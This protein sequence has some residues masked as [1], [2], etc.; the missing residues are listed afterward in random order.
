MTILCFLDADQSAYSERMNAAK[1]ILVTGTS[2]V[3]GAGVLPAQAT[4]PTKL[5]PGSIK[6]QNSQYWSWFA[7]RSW[8]SVDNSNGI[9][10]TSGDLRR[11]ID[12]GASSLPCAV[13]DSVTASVRGHFSQQRRFVRQE[14]RK[15]WRGFSMRRSQIR[16]LPESGYGPLYFRQAL[17]VSGRTAGRAYG[18]RVTMD[19]SLA[20]GPTYCFYRNQAL[21]A[22]AAGLARSLR[23]LRSVQA[24]IS[25]FA[26]GI[27]WE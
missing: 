13:G 15:S 26:P 20:N 17:R 25:Y 27:P 2:L 23:E 11:G 16:Q 1:M 21:Y 19:Y 10:I 9:V 12:I 6:H 5:P 3:I 4:A 22:P 7:P 14:L 8:T 18:G 24:S